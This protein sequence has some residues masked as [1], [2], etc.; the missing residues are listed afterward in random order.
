MGICHK[1]YLVAIDPGRT[2]WGMCV[3]D[4]DGKRVCG[5]SMDSP[6]KQWEL[7]RV[8]EELE[9]QI[10]CDLGLRVSFSLM[11]F[12]AIEGTYHGKAGRKQIASLNQTIGIFMSWAHRSGSRTKVAVLELVGKG[13]NWMQAY[14]LVGASDEQIKAYANTAEE[15]TDQPSEEISIHLAEACLQAR[16]AWNRREMLWG[17]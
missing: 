12:C 10:M 2:G 11:E 7:V 9:Y 13:Q 3:L 1:A 5:F 17:S 4:R 16:W 6:M 14:G 15:I 8:L